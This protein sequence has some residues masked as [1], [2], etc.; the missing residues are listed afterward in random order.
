MSYEIIGY[1]LTNSY[2]GLETIEMYHK[3]IDKII[4]TWLKI[5]KDG[6]LRIQQSKQD[7]AIFKKYFAKG[8]LIPILQNYQ[9]DSA[10]SNEI[11]KKKKIVGNVLQNIINYLEGTGLTGINLDLEGVYYKNKDAYTDFVEKMAKLFHKN[12]YKLGLSIPA[13]VENNKDSTWSGAYDYN[14]LGKLADKIIIMAYDFHWSGGPP[15]PIAPITW[16][17]DVIDYALIEIPQEKI[18]LGCGFYGYDWDLTRNERAEGVVYS[19]IKKYQD[20]YGFN[21]EW[22]QESKSPYFFYEK[23]GERH[24]VWF[25]NKESIRMKVELLEKYNLKGAA[26]WRLGQEDKEVWQLF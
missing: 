18:Y 4:P 10:I 20:K 21:I 12:G 2:S 25:E 23:N 7:T 16:V 9:M 3:F 17:Q 26:F 8:E 13:K 22:D 19:Q 11:I 24:E 15:G 1:H 5:K 6:E 14:I